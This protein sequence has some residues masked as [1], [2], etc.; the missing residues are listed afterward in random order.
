MFRRMAIVSGGDAART[1]GTGPA[2]RDAGEARRRQSRGP[3]VPRILLIGDVRVPTHLL[4]QEAGLAARVTEVMPA[5]AT[6]AVRRGRYDCIL[7]EDRAGSS[8]TA[9]VLDGLVRSTDL[10][11]PVIVLAGDADERRA[12]KLLEKGA[13]DHLAGSALE[14]AS[15]A[16][17]IRRGIARHR[18]RKRERRVT[19]LRVDD[20]AESMRRLEGENE[21]LAELNRS[22][23]ETV[24]DVAHE[25]RTPLTVIKDLA[26]LLG[27]G[28]VG[29]LDGQQQELIE[30]ILRRAD[31]LA[32][33]VDDMLD[34]SRL[35]SGP[36]RV[37][38]ERCD[39]EGI[40]ERHLSTLL[41]RATAAGV[42]MSVDLPGG[43]P[44]AMCDPE[45]IG[46]VILN[47][48]INAIK[49]TG[50]GGRVRLWASHEPGAGMVTVGVSDDGPGIAPEQLQQIFCRFQQGEQARGGAKGFG[51]GLS[52]A[53]AL[54]RL[55]GGTIG[56]ES[57]P[58]A[59][60]VFTFTIPAASP[61]VD[62]LTAMPAAGASVAA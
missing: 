38:V 35:E 16:Q 56:V 34:T 10:P 23:R 19:A 58:G 22:A 33:M 41:G 3:G 5:E 55:N 57:A 39:L 62:V 40:V 47:L 31:D 24:E 8:A 37:A 54:V 46:R 21:R 53:S 32:A 9:S 42:H 7:L 36:L 6:G 49:F 11:A 2:G 20:L 13:A 48:A 30:V 59:G 43:L 28:V 29:A 26:G 45:K 27:D 50:E 52:I 4:L 61:A 44:H 14:P 18:S 17:A 15:L 25:F 1:A 51:L 12:L 60:S